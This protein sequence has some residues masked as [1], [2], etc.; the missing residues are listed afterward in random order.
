MGHYLGAMSEQRLRK[1]N[2]IV[3]QQHCIDFM[4]HPF[5]INHRGMRMF[6]FSYE[7]SIQH[8]STKHVIYFEKTQVLF[9]C[10]YITSISNSYLVTCRNFDLDFLPLFPCHQEQLPILA[11]VIGYSRVAAAYVAPTSDAVCRYCVQGA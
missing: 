3:H 9:T 11:T 8:L 10:G 7:W 4:F 1:T 6:F 5:K 2:C